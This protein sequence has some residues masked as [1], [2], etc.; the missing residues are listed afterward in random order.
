MRGTMAVV[1]AWACLLALPSAAAD[2]ASLPPPAG[3]PVYAPVSMIAGDVSLALGYFSFEGDGT[4]EA[5]ATARLGIPLAAGWTEL[6][7]LNGLSGFER[8]TYFTYG[9]FSHT[10]WTD[11]QYAL[12]LLVGA[13]SLDGNE[14]VTAGAEAAVFLPSASFVGLVAHSWGSGGLPDFW[15][16]SGEAR[17]YWGPD[18]KVLGN[19]S[20]NTFNDAW[21][22]TAGAEHRFGGTL[23]SV[24]GEATYYTNTAG[25]GYELF[26]GLRLSFDQ[27]G[28]TLQ[29]HD[30]DVPFAAGRAIA[31]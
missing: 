21:K 30:R 20:Y 19:V 27:P 14:A 15:S 16:A 24:F 10:Y 2:F 6:I 7:E 28:Q 11:E 9:A 13:S 25:T 18:N 23:A 12:G 22:L 17:W 29:G 8:N 1:G 3:D 4:G 26:S 31:Y 5:W